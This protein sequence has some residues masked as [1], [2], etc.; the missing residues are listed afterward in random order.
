MNRSK[1]KIQC[2]AVLLTLLYLVVG[3]RQTDLSLHETATLNSLRQVNDWPL[4][5]MHYRGEY[6]QA[7]DHEVDVDQALAAAVST[8]GTPATAEPAWACSLFAALGDPTHPLYARNFDWQHSPAVL[9]FTDAPDAYASV[10]MVDI[11]YLGFEGQRAQGIDELPLDEVRSLLRAPYLPFDGMNERGLAI[12]MAAVPAGNMLVDPNKETLDS[13]RVMREVLDRAADVD[14][15]LDTLDH[16]NIDFGGGP[17]LHYLIAD[18]TGRALLVEYYQGQRFIHPNRQPWHLATNYL[19]S[20]VQT[21]QGH[22]D[23]YDTLERRLSE[24]QGQ[25]TPEQ[26]MESL[27]AVAQGSTQWSITYHLNTGQIQ[28]AMGRN[29]DEMHTFKLWAEN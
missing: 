22:C 23:R 15:A 11:G 12:G 20:S 10:S 25:L 21:P 8:V 26:A 18:R 27:S 5:V 4:Y 14:E 6:V 29:Y 1:A 7:G 19:V 3:C 2:L 17:P 13:L 28:V 16:Y 24:S 9:L